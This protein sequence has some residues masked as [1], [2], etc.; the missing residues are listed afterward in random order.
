V[1]ALDALR[2]QFE[3]AAAA[4][5][6]QVDGFTDDE[7]LWEPVQPCWSVRRR[8]ETDWPHVWGRGDL[9]VEDVGPGGPDA[10][11]TPPLVTTIAWKVVHLAAWLDVYR[12]WITDDPT[13]L[14][15]DEYEIPGDARTAVAWLVRA[16]DDF[17]AVIDRLDETDL[18]RVLTTFFGERRSISNLVRGMTLEQYH[19]SAEIGCLRDLRRGHARADWW[20]EDAAND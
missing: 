14:P 1:P 15:L 11:D 3:H 17:L 20:P 19:H 9:V 18:A 2:R 4:A 5:R 13:R 12:T 10:I 16:Q 8:G 7:F 6:W